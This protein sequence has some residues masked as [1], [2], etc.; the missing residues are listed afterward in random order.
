M[1]DWRPIKSRSEARR[2]VKQGAVKILRNDEWYTVTDPH[3]R[4]QDGDVVKVGKRRFVRF[5][6]V[7]WI[8]W[9]NG[10]LRPFGEKLVEVQGETD[11]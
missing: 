3:E 10:I 1:L 7:S 11:G 8:E 5:K 9:A 6:T 2:L 4:I